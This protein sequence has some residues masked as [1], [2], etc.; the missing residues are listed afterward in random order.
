MGTMVYSLL[1]VM[2]DLYHQ[3]YLPFYPVM[4]GHNFLSSPYMKS[5]PELTKASLICFQE[6]NPL[7]N[8]IVD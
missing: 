2:P 3:Q 7:K 4:E 1:W 8:E 6:G 5:M